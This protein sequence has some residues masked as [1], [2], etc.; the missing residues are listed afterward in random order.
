MAD[1]PWV[2]INVDYWRNPKV[3]SA[4]FLAATMNLA[5][6]AYC[7]EQLTDGFVPYG[8]VGMLAAPMQ[9]YVYDPPMPKGALCGPGPTHE[10]AHDFADRLV[11]AGLWEEVEGGWLIVN[12]L[13]HQPS[14]VEVEARKAQAREAGRKGGQA[15]AA[16]RNAEQSAK[17]VAKRPAKRPLEQNASGSQAPTPV[18][19][20]PPTP[21]PASS[22][23]ANEVEVE[24]REAS[25]SQD[26]SEEELEEVRAI[27]RTVPWVPGSLQ[28]EDVA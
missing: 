3:A 14:R 10:G 23:V 6:I 4:G 12:Y 17:P 8:V 24:L 5:A 7:A 28:D 26:C 2:A 20:P 25:T 21:L 16:K 18:P 13:D 11:D 22:G 27:L 1:A 9:N 15:R 19:V